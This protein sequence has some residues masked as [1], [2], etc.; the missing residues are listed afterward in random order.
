MRI[1]IDL[2]IFAFIIIFIITK[3]IEIYSIMMIFVILHEL[4]HMI[5]GLILGF[6]PQK[7]E[8]NPMGLSL[9]LEPK[10]NDYNLKIKRTNLLEIKK[11]LIASVGPLVNIIIAT[12]LALTADESDITYLIFYSNLVIAIFNLIPIYPLDGGRIIYGILNIILGKWK[13]K[14]I[15]NELSFVITVIL[16]A[17]SSIAIYYYKNIAILIML[18]YI[19]I[20]VLKSDRKYKKELKIYEL[21]KK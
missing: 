6:K 20:I 12:I 1:R 10:M 13:A 3:Q 4:S 21:M 2:K 19:W 11:I 9:S 8:L 14:K 16:T 18:V 7:I 15:V 5:I 17:I